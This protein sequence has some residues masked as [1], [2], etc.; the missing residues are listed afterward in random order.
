MIERV[1]RVGADLRKDAV[2]FVIACDLDGTLLDTPGLIVEAC[3]AAFTS[4]DVAVPDAGEIRATIGLP[5]EQAFS[6][7]L[8]LPEDDPTVTRGMRQYRALFDEIA[9]PEAESL[10]FPGVSRGL[11]TLRA[12]GFT[13]A[14]ATSKS[15]AGAHALL[16]AAGLRDRFAMVVGADQVSRPKPDPEMARLIM[17]RC[18]VSGERAVMVGDTSHDVVM[19]KAAGMRSIA[20]TSGVHGREQLATAGPDRVADDFDEVVA[21][22]L[23]AR[24][25]PAW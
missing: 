8:G 14:V 17:R 22:I 1:H 4:I 12:A 5:L 2:T 9:L 20:V 13:L 6:T 25:D 24:E 11:A 21:T 18:G 19:A 10:P 3:T 7:L 23:A 15:H 16:A